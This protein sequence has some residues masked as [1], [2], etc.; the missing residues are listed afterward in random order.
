MSGLHLKKAPGLQLRSDQSPD[1]KDNS[2]KDALVVMAIFALLIG[3][4]AWLAGNS[5][6]NEWSYSADGTEGLAAM[7]IGGAFVNFGMLLLTFW[8]AVSALIL[9]LT[10][11]KAEI[12]VDGRSPQES[13]A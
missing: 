6:A 2:Y 9:G 5:E 1:M 11:S 8:L 12:V 4:I 13:D 10:R 3:G 7:A